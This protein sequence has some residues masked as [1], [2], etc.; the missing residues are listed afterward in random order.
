MTDHGLNNLA[1][2]EASPMEIDQETYYIFKWSPQRISNKT[3][4]KTQKDS[5]GSQKKSK[6]RIS[7]LNQDRFKTKVIKSKPGN[8]K[9]IDLD[10]PF[11]AAL[12]GLKV[13]D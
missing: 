7:K 2:E 12:M 6:K 13:K 1:Q 3:N 8:K 9:E 5:R 4:A 11:A 10:N